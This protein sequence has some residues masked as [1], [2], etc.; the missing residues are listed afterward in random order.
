MWNPDWNW[1]FVDAKAWTQAERDWRG[2][3]TRENLETL[4]AHGRVEEH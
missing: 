1:G 2:W 3:M 4:L